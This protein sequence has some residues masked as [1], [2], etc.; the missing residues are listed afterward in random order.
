[1][2]SHSHFVH[3]FHTTNA[4]YQNVYM[5]K[6]KMVVFFA[7]CLFTINVCFV[8]YVNFSIVLGI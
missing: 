4:L 1:M 7:Y 2:S 6:T 5:Y 3:F 8:N